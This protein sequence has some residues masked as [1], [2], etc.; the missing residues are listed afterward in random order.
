MRRQTVEPTSIALAFYRV[1]DTHPARIGYWLA[2][3]LL[4]KGS[5][6]HLVSDTVTELHLKSCH[7][8]LRMM[9]RDTEEG[10]ANVRAYESGR[11]DIVGIA[12]V[13][14][15][16]IEPRGKKADR[17][18]LDR[19]LGRVAYHIGVGLSADFIHAAGPVLRI[20]ADPLP[21]MC[22][23][24]ADTAC[25]ILGPQPDDA[26]IAALEP[27]RKVSMMDP[28]DIDRF[29][30]DIRLALGVGSAQQ[31]RELSEDECIGTFAGIVFTDR[32]NA[33]QRVAARAALAAGSLIVGTQVAAGPIIAQLP[34]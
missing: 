21:G 13:L 7:I 24:E 22:E 11:F 8:R 19:L 12:A 33:P 34:L 3:A 20:E 29:D 5:Q 16:E 23:A 31:D 9:F 6:L 14:M 2:R 28:G 18:T 1:P 4:A 25:S 30:A 26:T 17:E 10:L 27:R 32:V 15:L